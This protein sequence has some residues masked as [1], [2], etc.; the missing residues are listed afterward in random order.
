MSPCLKCSSF[1]R[2]RSPRTVCSS[3]S[4]PVFTVLYCLTYSGPA[5]WLLMNH[6]S[7]TAGFDLPDV[8][9]TLTLSLIWYRARPPVILG[10]VSGSTEAC[11]WESVRNTGGGKGEKANVR[12]FYYFFDR[13]WDLSVQLLILSAIR[14]NLSESS[15]KGGSR[16]GNKK[17]R[18]ESKFDLTSQ[19][20]LAFS[21]SSRK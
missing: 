3:P 19:I 17:K 15:R 18:S 6:A 14:G 7:F 4:R 11:V 5:C 13:L 10:S 16:I 20:L 21:S 2:K 8:Q 1:T 12:K 9:L